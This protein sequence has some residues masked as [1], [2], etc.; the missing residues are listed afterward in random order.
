MYETIKPA[1]NWMGRFFYI[2]NNFFSAYI[3][4][5]VN[6]DLWDSGCNAWLWLTVIGNDREQKTVWVM[7]NLDYELHESFVCI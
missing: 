3:T 1:K 7:G 5:G 4:I 6:L 2:K